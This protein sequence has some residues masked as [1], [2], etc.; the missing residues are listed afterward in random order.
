M[1]ALKWGLP[2]AIVL[3]LG[4]YF[5]FQY[6]K[7]ETKKASPEDTVV[8]TDGDYEMKVNYNRPYKKGREIF[9][10]LVPYGEVWRT[11][12]NEATTISFNKKIIIEDEEVPAGT[13]TL[14]TI[15]NEKKWTII[16]NSE[17][18]DWGVGWDGKANRDPDYDVF[19]HQFPVYKLNEK[20]EQ[21][22][23][24]LEY[25]VNLSISWDRTK[26]TVPIIY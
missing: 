25:K 22:T 19:K 11:G 23:I 15:P 17:L 2:I 26:I 3:F 16:L 21:F 6:I 9:G 24:D 18:V 12:A 1:K 10:K 13:Y 7:A 20:V 8:F 4:T 5:Y 14:W